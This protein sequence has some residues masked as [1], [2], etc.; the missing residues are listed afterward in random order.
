VSVV[1]AT[2]FDG[3]TS[4]AHPVQVSAHAGYVLTIHARDWQRSD[5][6]EGVRVTPRVAGIHR[7]LVLPDGGQLQV[8]DN[9]AVDA[10]FPDR[11]LGAAWIDRLER[12]PAAVATS[13][14]VTVVGIVFLI[15]YG[16]PTAAEKIAA[17]IPDSVAHKMGEQTVALLGRFGFDKSELPA[18]R[19][20]ELQATFKAYVADL[21]DPAHYQLRF[22]DAKMANAFALPGGIIVVTDEMVRVIDA[23]NAKGAGSDGKAGSDD[24]CKKNGWVCMDELKSASKDKPAD[25][26]QDDEGELTGPTNKA[27]TTAPQANELKAADERFLAVVAH[28]IGHEEHKHVLRSVLQGSA[29]VLIGAY[30]TGDV[31]SAS[32]LVVSVPTFLLDSHYSRGFEAEADDYAFASLARHGISPGRFAEVM[33]AMRRRDPFMRKESGYLSTHPPTLDRILK[34]QEAAERFQ[35]A[36]Q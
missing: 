7:T 23:T 12:H 15:F 9:D 2:Y 16:I 10:W 5:L 27:G 22:L 18:R 19:R 3:R 35:R 14:L 4:R 29:V 36:E 20:D 1:A 21:P 17:R 34:A 24:I 26:D 13:L 31:G 6:L 8:Q 33:T 25:D 11:D 30:F 32:T 28:E